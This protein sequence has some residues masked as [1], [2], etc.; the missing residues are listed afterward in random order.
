MKNYEFQENCKLRSG[1]RIIRKGDCYFLIVKKDGITTRKNLR[2]DKVRCSKVFL[3]VDNFEKI[4]VL[5]KI[6][7]KSEPRIYCH[8]IDIDSLKKAFHGYEIIDFQLDGE[9]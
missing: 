1:S 6:T 2:V 3:K 7:Q 5:I 8:R 9:V 4:V